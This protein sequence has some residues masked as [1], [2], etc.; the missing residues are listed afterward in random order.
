MQRSELKSDPCFFPQLRGLVSVV[1]PP[2]LQRY[3]KNPLLNQYVADFFRFPYKKT[4]IMYI[5]N[6]TDP[7]E[8][9]QQLI[10]IRED[11]NNRLSVLI[12]HYTGLS[13]TLLA[14][15]TLFGDIASFHLLQR[16][17]LIV[18]MTCLLASVLSGVWCC[19]AMHLT[20]EK[21]LKTLID[22]VGE[23]QALAQGRSKRPCRIFILCEILPHHVVSRRSTLMDECHRCVV[24][25]VSSITT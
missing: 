8:R 9:L 19:M 10:D 25:L 16:I 14:L 22:K 21:T 18:C 3:K 2:T 20:L 4:S 23:G 7:Q 13:A 1:I 15:L 5:F 12:R 17:L 24:L 11:L 6:T